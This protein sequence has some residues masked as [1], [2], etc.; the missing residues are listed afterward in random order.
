MVQQGSTTFLH[1]VKKGETLYGIAKN[2]GVSTDDIV[3]FNPEANGG[4]KEGETL[5]IPQS[6]QAIGQD[7]IRTAVTPQDTAI[8]Y[9]TIR[10]GDT[11]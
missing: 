9:V 2:Y 4:I 6:S 11:M 8:I 7:T 10:Q 5:Q 1:T 3:K